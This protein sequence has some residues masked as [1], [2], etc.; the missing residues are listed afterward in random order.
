MIKPLKRPTVQHYDW[1]KNAQSY[2]TLPLNAS[3]INNKKCKRLTVKKRIALKVISIVFKV[4]QKVAKPNFLIS[5]NQLRTSFKSYEY[6]FQTGS[7]DCDRQADRHTDRHARYS[8]F[9]PFGT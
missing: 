1:C 7:K 3:L 5:S 6:Q 4:F 2:F 9:T 8:Y